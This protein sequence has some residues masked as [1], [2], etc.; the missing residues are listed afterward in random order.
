M[1]DF[2]SLYMALDASNA[3]RHKTDAMVAWFVRA[4][5]DDAAWASYFL[6]GGR[7]L[8]PVSAAQLRQALIDETGLPEWLFEASYQAVGDLAE[9]ITHLLPDAQ[10][11]A[12]DPGLAVWMTERILPLRD[13]PALVQRCR[14][15]DW[16]RQTDAD[17]RFVLNKV[18]TGGM[19][20]GVS[21]QLVIRALA[22][23]FD[24]DPK[25]IAQRLIGYTDKLHRP[26]GRRFQ[27]LVGSVGSDVAT[28]P[29]DALEQ[30]G[31]PF[32]FF[33]AQPL[34]A[35]PASLG[36]R[37][38]WLVEWKW[39]GI[40]AQLIRRMG[41]TWIWSRGEELMS[42][43][44]PELQALQPP[45]PDGTVLDG[46]LVCW[47]ADADA[48][49]SFA[50][51]QHRIGRKHLSGKILADAPVAL[52]AYDLLELAG[53]DIRD[54]PQRQRRASLVDLIEPLAQAAL[55]LSPL[56][57]AADW[58]ALADQ[59]A[60]ARQRGVEGLMLKRSD[61]CYGVGRSKAS[62]RGE[63]WKWKLDPM[64]I[65]CVL[66]YAQ[67][68]HG[69]RASLY[70]DYTFAVWSDPPGVSDRQLVPFAK[71]YSGL[72]DEEIR[73]VDAVIRKTIL[74][75]FGPVRSV[76]PT[77]VFEL[78]FEGI[79]VSTRHKSGLAVRFP[80][81][82]RR[83]LDKPVEQADTLADL[84]SLLPPD[85]AAIARPATSS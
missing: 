67:A 82:L 34:T 85:I 60:L 61:A 73:E 40:R 66:I 4:A 57:T 31:Q 36:A 12:S 30:A 27:R 29:D 11:P 5:P 68:G 46:E 76:R 15:R 17:T 78:G 54:W 1:K 65:D 21:R 71:A 45:M 14:I 41:R 58:S 50:R 69:R 47:A 19:R 22:A 6:A 53:V 3:T 23:A 70:T 18:L 37:D 42:D 39:D 80:R 20:V 79:Q 63:W 77:L 16:W 55:R 84:R 9:T 81:M 44:F 72:S 28:D 52:I 13:Q 83:R 33:L 25:R 62:R 26:D 2:A 49:M 35:E 8:R 24:Q 43:R 48:P 10:S 56:I 38:D 7:P 32:P 74:E 64:S 51:L 75:K 59:R